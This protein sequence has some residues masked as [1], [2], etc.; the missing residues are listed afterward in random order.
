M[1]RRVA[2]LALAAA[3]AAGCAPARLYRWNGY[4]EALYRHYRNPQDREAWVASLRTVILEAEQAGER[5]PPGIYAEYGYALF[6]EGQTK[7]ASAW[8]EKEKA[9]WPE[10][11]VLMEKMIRNAA[12]QEGQPPAGARGPAGAVERAGEQTP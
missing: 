12:L 5:V 9:T 1:C 2:T 6:E 3:L 10:S 8:F 4:D 11:R 7:D